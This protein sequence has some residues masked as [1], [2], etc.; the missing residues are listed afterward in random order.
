MKRKR[1]KRSPSSSPTRYRKPE[2]RSKDTSTPTNNSEPDFIF[3]C[4]IRYIDKR[5]A[6]KS[7]FLYGWASHMKRFDPLEWQSYALYIVRYFHYGADPKYTRLYVC[8][9]PLRQL[10]KDVIGDYF[11]NPIKVDDVHIIKPYH[12]LFHYRKELEK[13]GRER[14]KK[15]EVNNKYLSLLLE[16]IQDTFKHDIKAYQEC[17]NSK[18]R[19]IAYSSLWT[20]FPPGTIVYRNSLDQ[21]RAYS[22]VG[23]RLN[24]YPTCMVVSFVDSD[25]EVFHERREEYTFTPYTGTRDACDIQQFGCIPLDMHMKAEK[26]RK[27]LLNRGRKFERYLGHYLRDH[28][29]NDRIPPLDPD[30]SQS[31]DEKAHSKAA[32]KP[33][34]LRVL[35]RLSGDD[36]LRANPIVYGFSLTTREFVGF[37]VDRIRRLRWDEKCFDNFPLRSDLKSLVKTFASKHV[38]KGKGIDSSVRCK[39]EA[40]V[41]LL[42]GPHG[43]GKRTMAKC[44]AE[45]FKRPL[46]TVSSYELGLSVQTFYN[47]LIAAMDLASEWQAML[48]IDEA[49]VYVN[50]PSSNDGIHNAFVG[51]LLRAL[52]NYSGVL[53]LTT[54]HDAAINDAIRSRIRLSI[55]YKSLSFGSRLL[56]WRNLLNRMLGGVDIEERHLKKL[57]ERQ[58]DGRQIENI[59]TVA[60]YVSI[61]QSV[62]VDFTMLE[63]AAKKQNLLNRYIAGFVEID[64]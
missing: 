32:S 13:I 3:K 35:E 12:C 37:F 64:Y 52:D 34:I 41:F 5:I 47:N 63:T 26:L 29:E 42:H 38:K 57:A 15:N 46:Y 58:F 51:A 30:G 31:G 10:L 2:T 60:K 22:V 43:A 11:D 8:P 45:H 44:V 40:T 59:I 9:R 20:L 28:H 14:F 50:G 16:F 48:L 1:P 36:L 49:D 23:F 4:E 55:P 27:N 33:S 6:D 54:H 56:V 39:R 21:D 62:C 18:A 7:H 61:I 24:T 53:F 25:G 19:S 17:I